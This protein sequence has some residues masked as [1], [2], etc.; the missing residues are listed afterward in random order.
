MVIGITVIGFGTSAPELFVSLQAAL[1]HSP[2]LSIGNVVGSNIANI[3]LILG[4]TA[5][6]VPC[7]SQRRTL[8]IDMPVMV[9]GC[10]L[11]FAVGMTGTIGRIA[12]VVGLAILIVF[13]TAEIRSSSKS[14]DTAPVEEEKPIEKP[15]MPLWKSIPIVLFSFGLL[16]LGANLLIKGASEIALQIG[17]IVGADPKELERVIGLTIVA[18][19]TSL[20]ELFASIMAA[21]KGES[22]MAVGNVIGSVTFN[23]LCGIGLTAAICP[24]ADSDRGFFADYALMMGLALLLWF[25]MRTSR[26]LERWEGMVLLAIYV[27]YIL[28]TVIA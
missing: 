3:A 26:K 5:A 25:F 23:I 2:G 15:S 13:V 24:I 7:V 19:G 14:A 20:P 12:G 28:Y 21:R 22:D 1:A 8:R 18:V 27:A 10:A 11:L 4:A 16:L 9:L 6:I 17:G